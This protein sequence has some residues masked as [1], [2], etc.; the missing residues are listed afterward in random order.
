L[1]GRGERGAKE[2]EKHFSQ[3]TQEYW[4]TLFPANQEIVSLR[5]LLLRSPSFFEGRGK[6]GAKQLRNTSQQTQ[7]YW[8]VKILFQRISAEPLT[9]WFDVGL[10]SL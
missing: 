1:K 2:I 6:E 4:A 8:N 9:S 10:P 7:E 3:Q 5:S